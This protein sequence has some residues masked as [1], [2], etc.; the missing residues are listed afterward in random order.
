MNLLSRENRD[1]SLRKMEVGDSFWFCG[2]ST[3]G[4]NSR[5]KMNVKPCIVKVATKTNYGTAESPR[6][7]FTWDLSQAPQLAKRRRGA[8]IDGW[9]SLLTLE[10]EDSVNLYDAR[11]TEL[12]NNCGSYARKQR[13]L[14]NCMATHPGNDNLADDAR[15]WQ[16]GL[17]DLERSYIKKLIELTT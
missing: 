5:F 14:L 9:N 6:W 16:D 8:S 17:S 13:M 1:E 15:T 7:S 3:E 4:K 2:A 12:A 11:I 10:E